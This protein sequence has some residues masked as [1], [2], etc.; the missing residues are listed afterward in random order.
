MSTYNWARKG[1]QERHVFLHFTQ[2][3]DALSIRTATAKE[4][5]EQPERCFLP[6][7]DIGELWLAILEQGLPLVASNAMLTGKKIDPETGNATAFVAE[8]TKPVIKDGAIEQKPW[9]FSVKQ[10]AAMGEAPANLT[11]R[12]NRYGG[13]LLIVGQIPYASKRKSAAKTPQE[14]PALKRQRVMPEA[15]A[16]GEPELKR[17]RAS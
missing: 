11:I 10:I 15:E 14:Q 16:T 9:A 3:F 5:E 8:A 1:E 2:R 17:R 7:R 12:S 6:S 4:I 13:P